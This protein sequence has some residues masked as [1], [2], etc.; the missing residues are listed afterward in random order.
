MGVIKKYLI[1]I[2]G[3]LMVVVFILVMTTGAD[4]SKGGFNDAMSQADEVL[5]KYSDIELSLYDNTTVSGSV[6]ID[7][8]NSLDASTGY[9]VKVKNGAS[10]SYTDYKY[11]TDP[12][13]AVLKACITNKS[14][15]TSYINPY[16]SFFAK[17]H[18]D[19][20]G[21]VDYITFEQK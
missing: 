21:Q 1:A 16:G 17:L 15:T 3:I 14:E 8:I 13:F 11:S 7:L 18:K 12:A 10:T 6:L 2:A 20:N 19:A 5:N 4:K 9:Y